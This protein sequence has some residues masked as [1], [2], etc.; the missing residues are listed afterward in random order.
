MAEIKRGTSGGLLKGYELQKVQALSADIV[1]MDALSLNF[2][3]MMEVTKNSRAR[4]PPHALKNYLEEKN[5]SEAINPLEAN[6]K[7]ILIVL[8]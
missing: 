5:G 6:D 7:R 3:F 8:F 2:W 4:Y 1:D